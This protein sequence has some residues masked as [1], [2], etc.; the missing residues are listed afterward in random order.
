MSSCNAAALV[1]QPA[2]QEALSRLVSEVSELEDC[3]SRLVSRLDFALEP[4]A[5]PNGCVDMKVP[6]GPV[7][8]TLTR[9]LSHTAGRVHD[10]CTSVH[11]VLSRLEL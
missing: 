2:A 6:T 5:E 10:I 7:V 3:M 9:E 1:K 11:H 4:T 8:S